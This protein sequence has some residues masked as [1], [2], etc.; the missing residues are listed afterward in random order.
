MNTS[1]RLIVGLETHIELSTKQKMF[2][3]CSADYF[4]K[5]PNSH[6]CPVCLGLP[7]ALPVPNLEAIRWTIMVGLALNCKINLESFFER[8]HYFYP[9]LPKGYQISQ[10]QKPLCYGGYLEVG[11]KKVHITRVHLEEDTGKLLHGAQLKNK[12]GSYLDFNRG[13]VPLIEVVTEPCIDSPELAA[14]YLKKL[15]LTIQ[16]LGV[17]DCDMEKGSMRCEPN[18]SLQKISNFQLAISKLPN[19]KVEV[20]NINSFRFVKKS[21][22]YEIERQKA[23]LETDTT[24]AQE[25]RRYVESSEKTESMR[26]KEEAHDYRYFPEPDIPPLRFDNTFIESIKKE[27]SAKE[28]PDTRVKLFTETYKLR[29][30]DANILVENKIYGN[31][32]KEIIKEKIDVVKIA[33]FMVNKKN[34]LEGKSAHEILSA[35]N[36]AYA[37]EDVDPN[38]IN[39][40]VHKVL[41][42]HVQAA[43]DYKAG[44]Q[45]ALQFLLGQVMRTIGKKVDTSKVITTLKN[46]LS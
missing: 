23:L 5:Q 13:G 10:Y 39:T 21:I 46:K 15:Q 16:Y 37:K 42:Q 4:Q 2:C 8:K 41:E 29:T 27:L 36:K 9:D 31:V 30:V 35:F 33:T 38:E 32:F 12:Q 1:Y 43:A 44:K 25:T 20:K 28:L 40:A 45:N 6:T 11:D 24:P 3:G 18:I 7:G 19:Y 26:G 22:E 17:S 34:V 14:Q